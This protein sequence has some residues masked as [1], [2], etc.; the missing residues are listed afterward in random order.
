MKRQSISTRINIILSLFGFVILCYSATVIYLGIQ[1]NGST[2]NV[3][4]NDMPSA[5]NT[6]AML[7]ELGD[8]NSNLLEYVLGETEEK[9]EYFGNY[10]EFLRFRDLISKDT[11]NHHIIERVVRIVD[12]HKEDAQKRVFDVYDPFNEKSAA[13]QINSLIRDVGQ[14]LEALLDQMKDEEIADVGSKPNLQEVINDD[15]PG[16]RF[17]LELVDEAGDMLADLDRFVLGDQAARRSFF[18]NALQ[19][20]SF[21]AQLKPLER[22]PQE[23]IRISEIER[24]FGELK[25]RGTAIFKVYS[26]TSK[27]DA[28]VAIDDLEHQSFSEAEKL[29]DELSDSARNDV[30][31]SMSALGSLANQISMVLLFA[32]VFVIVLTVSILIY[33]RRTIFNPIAQINITIDKLRKGERNFKISTMSRND[34]L[35]DILN[36]LEQFQSELTELDDLRDKSELLQVESINQRD[37]AESALAQLKN[38]QAK[39]VAN[40]KMASLGTLVAGV[41]HEVNTPLG[42][43]VTMSSTIEF[44]MKK[45]LVD[46]KSGKLKRSSLDKFEKET[47]ESLSLLGNSLEQASHLIHNFKKVAIDQTSSNRREFNLLT[48]IEEIMSTLQH[49]IKRTNIKFFI[50]GANDIVMDSYPGP[51]GQVITNLFNNAI[52]HAFE[53]RDEGE[54]HIRFSKIGNEIRL[55]FSDNGTGVS[56][57]HLAKLFDP[58]YTTKENNGGTGLGTHIIYNLVTD[59]L[60][61]KIIASSDAGQGLSYDIYFKDM[62]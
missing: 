54:I 42:V 7:E 1:V 24:L 19:F 50:E 53:G 2:E 34:E 20:E 6:L 52:L 46:V 27:N 60:N 13:E 17:Y 14:P 32:T 40:E 21:L 3:I 23:I 4:K 10:E 33:F 56:E 62:Q 26:A 8:M 37:K 18:N 49:Q 58:F 51:F 15:M 31:R 41:A 12:G 57:E 43:S 22:K 5:L 30:N 28:L 39:L 25:T 36:S 35:T 44:N 16:V 9:Q 48:T 55:L 61:G 47:T 38:T 59:T 29:L 11:N 45:F